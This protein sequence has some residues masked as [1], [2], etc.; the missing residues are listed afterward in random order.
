MEGLGVIGKIGRSG[1]GAIDLGQVLLDLGE[2]R[3][4]GVRQFSDFD[5][6]AR[7][8]IDGGGEVIESALRELKVFA[9]GKF[10]VFA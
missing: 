8:V 6:D 10:L 1:E 9:L 4:I 7:P 3:L 2:S 5:V